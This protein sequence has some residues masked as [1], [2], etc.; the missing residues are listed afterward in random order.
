VQLGMRSLPVDAARALLPAASVVG[1]S[2]HAAREAASAGADFIVFGT[3]FDS[4]SHPG[5]AAAGIAALAD[6]AAMANVPVVA[7]GGITA[8]RVA[9]ALQAGAYG[10]AVLSGVWAAREPVASALDYASALNTGVP[11]PS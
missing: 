4:P 11:V 9:A 2:A 10:V 6:T 3:V 7:I 8:D 1:Y 5:Q